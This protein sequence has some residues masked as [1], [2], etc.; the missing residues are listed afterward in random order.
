[1]THG[2]TRKGTSTCDK[3]AGIACLQQLYLSVYTGELTLQQS[4]TV[5]GYLKASEVTLFVLCILEVMQSPCSICLLFLVH[6]P[7]SHNVPAGQG[8]IPEFNA[9]ITNAWTRD[10]SSAEFGP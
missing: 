8:W 3:D 4:A 2:F 5:T 9:E 1:M 6:Q 10:D 7:S